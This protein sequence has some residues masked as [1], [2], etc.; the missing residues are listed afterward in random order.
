MT[1]SLIPKSIECIA[2]ISLFVCSM[3]YTHSFR[4]LFIFT[5][6]RLLKEYVMLCFVIVRFNQLA[7][8]GL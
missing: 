2:L 6:S 8:V 5:S 7:A 1:F 4:L 3:L